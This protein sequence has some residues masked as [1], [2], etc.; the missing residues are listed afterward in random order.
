MKSVARSCGPLSWG[1][2]RVKFVSWVVVAAALAVAF[3]ILRYFCLLQA[4]NIPP[5]K[6]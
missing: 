3:L 1:I 5:G 2:C 6:P 4:D